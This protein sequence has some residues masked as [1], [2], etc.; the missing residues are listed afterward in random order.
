MSRVEPDNELTQQQTHYWV[1]GTS[2]HN[3]HCTV[4]SSYKGCYINPKQ[5]LASDPLACER[6]Q[7]DYRNIYTVHCIHRMDLRVPLDFHNKQ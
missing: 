3:I 4:R 2:G 6:T 1:Q 5:L 7:Y